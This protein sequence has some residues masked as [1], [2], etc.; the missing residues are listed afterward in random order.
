MTTSDAA[1][2][3]RTG[4]SQLGLR[5]IAS[6]VF[7]GE[8]KTPTSRARAESPRGGVSAG[9][10]AST[11]RLAAGAAIKFDSTCGTVASGIPSTEIPFHS[12][13]SAIARW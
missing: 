8:K 4:A 6:K 7:P 2:Q 10:V 1:I 13:I 12:R 9:A 3:T 11:Y 5:A